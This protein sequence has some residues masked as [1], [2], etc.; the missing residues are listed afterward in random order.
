MKTRAYI[1]IFVLS[2]GLSGFSQQAD[3]NDPFQKAVVNLFAQILTQ[4]EEKVYIQTDKPYYMNGEKP[5]FRAFLLH[6]SSLKAA[7]WSRYVYV[8]LVSPADSVVLRQQIRPDENELFYGALSL[9]EALPEGTYRIR[10]YTR[11]ME[12]AGE[13]FFF[14]RPVYIGDP[15]ASATDIDMKFSPIDNQQVKLNLS[16]KDPKTN[17]AK[18]PKKLSLQR[19]NEN[20]DPNNQDNSYEEKFKLNEKNSSRVVLMDYQDG[21]KPFKKYV[22]IPYFDNFPE[23][24]FYPEGG[25]LIAGTTCRVAFKALLPGAKPAKVD[26]AIYNSKDEEVAKF[27]AEESGMG[28]FSLKP[29]EGET[30]YAQ[31]HYNEQTTKINLPTVQASGYALQT[32]WETDSLNVKLNYNVAISS[33]KGYLLIH[34]QGIPVYLKPWDFS[35]SEIKLN[36]KLFVTGVSHVLFLDADFRTLSERLVFNNLQDQITPEITISQKTFKAREKVDVN[37]KINTISADT[38]PPSFAISVTDDKDV[39][40]DTTTNIVSE[41]LLSSEL[42]GTI[43]NPAWYFSND[44]KAFAEAD[45]LM[46]TN[47]WRNYHVS[48]ALENNLVKPKIKPEQS[49]NISGTIKGRFGKSYKE[50]QIT[51]RTLGYKNTVMTNSD[52]NGRF[53]FNDFEYPDSTA[54]FIRCY[55]KN[56]K[57]DKVMDLKLDSITY[58]SVRIPLESSSVSTIK[59][60]ELDEYLTKSNRKYLNE[61]GLRQVDLPEVVIKERKKEEVKRIDNKMLMIS[62]PDVSVSIDEIEA[63]PPAHYIELLHKLNRTVKKVIVYWDGI[64]TDITLEDLENESFGLPTEH[65]VPPVTEVAQVDLYIDIVSAQFFSA[66]GN[67]VI[68]FTTWPPEH[69]F[70]KELSI[71]INRKMTVP[72]GYQTPVEFYSPQYDTPELKYDRVADLRSTIYWKPNL[73][74]DIDGNA[75][76]SFYTADAKTTYSV[77][78]EGFTN[79]KKLIYCRK[80]AVVEVKE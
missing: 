26:G 17:E 67:P 52:E 73:E 3:K 80:K 63:D 62:D 28:T 39:K 55:N 36:K 65:V 48:E 66:S 21:K 54:Y 4:P 16:F 20:I 27:S 34:H 76:V 51:M 46:M 10:A 30:Y 61:K 44:P 74:A 50:G 45:L 2:L 31:C 9:P 22:S 53:E 40:L 49:Q 5:F 58:P 41:I 24:T 43:S 77:V 38:I 37:V 13:D 23:V 1:L 42:K 11:Y 59:K 75:S 35:R 60:V 6:A 7:D 71:L 12:N 47:G 57:E 8:E 78:V 25:Q 19:G 68:A 29:I 56:G 33:P 64:Q 14:S 18:L 32:D 69:Y 70:Q 72:L 79:E 15:N